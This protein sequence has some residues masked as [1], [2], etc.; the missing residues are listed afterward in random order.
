MKPLTILL[1]EDNPDDAEL[2]LRAFAEAKVT[3]PLVHVQDGVEALDYLFARNTFAARDPLNVPVM[4]L[5]DLR[6]PRLDGLDV[7]RAIRAGEHT[8]HIPVVMLTSS[9]HPRDRAAAYDLHVNS[10]VQKP[11]DYDRFV[12]TAG[13]LGRYWA[14]LNLP[15]R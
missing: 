14:V 5:L 7:L 3:N 13:Q 2:A 15:S 6:L 9:N 4:V 8:R 11:V 12:E 10:Y 1:V